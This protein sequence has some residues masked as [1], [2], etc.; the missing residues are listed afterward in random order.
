MWPLT[1]SSASALGFSLAYRRPVASDGLDLSEAEGINEYKIIRANEKEQLQGLNDRFCV[2]RECASAGDA[3]LRA[4]GQEGRLVG[5]AEEVQ[6][7]RVCCQEESCG[8]EGTERA[9]KVQQ[10]DVDSAMLACL[11]LEQKVES[12]WDELA[13]VRQVHD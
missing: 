12:L 9:L 11:D 7:L 1:C 4:G 13:L 8:R 5:L 2:H 6:W 10:R 3:E